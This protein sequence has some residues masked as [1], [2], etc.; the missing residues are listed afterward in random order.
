LKQTPVGGAVAAVVEELGHI[1]I[2][3]AQIRS[4]AEKWAGEGFELPP[5]R[6]PVFPD[7]SA[8]GTSVEDGIDF[9]LV[10]NGTDL[11]RRDFETYEKCVAEYDGIERV[12]AFGFWTFSETPRLHNADRIASWGLDGEQG[13]RGVFPEATRLGFYHLTQNQSVRDT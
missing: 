5:W 8:A 6:A 10:G 3:P 7:E 1:E 2:D 9:R 4:V 13:R 11:A 12:G